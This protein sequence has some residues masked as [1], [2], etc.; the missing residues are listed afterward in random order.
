MIRQTQEW[1]GE[2][3]FLFDEIAIYDEEDRR[4]VLKNKET[5]VNV[6]ISIEFLLV[7]AEFPRLE[8][9]ILTPGPI[10]ENFRDLSDVCKNIKCLRLKYY[11]ESEGG[12]YCLNLSGLDHLRTLDC[13][14]LYNF[15][16]L[17]SLEKLYVYCWQDKDLSKIDGIPLKKLRITIGK[18]VSLN[19]SD[20]IISLQS[21]TLSYDRQLIDFSALK[22][23]KHLK[24]LEINHCP[25]LHDMSLLGKLNSL[26]VLK[27]YGNNKID[28]IDFIDSL[29]NLRV[30]M[31]EYFIAD[32]DISKLLR[33]DYAT[34][35]VDRKH[36]NIK[37][38]ILPKK[39][40]QNEIGI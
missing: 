16:G 34:V 27:L 6:K 32:G 25:K 21:L 26:E 14:S 30:V 31:I 5:F 15:C 36:Y 8:R 33:M 38:N 4:E 9:L 7:L 39:W 18:L 13:D 28:N 23:M 2:D 3:S 37:D 20:A 1:V 19:G 35:F 12:E 17:K 40:G 10:P 29:K 22:R 11:E 24:Y